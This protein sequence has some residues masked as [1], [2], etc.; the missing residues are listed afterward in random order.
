MFRQLGFENLSGFQLDNLEI[1]NLTFIHEET[2]RF[3][4]CVLLGNYE[5]YLCVFQV[6]VENGKLIIHQLFD[7]E[8]PIP[9]GRFRYEGKNTLK[10]VAND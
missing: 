1:S 8:I 3:A 5:T 10:F 4:I 9:N 6:D 7:L 2:P